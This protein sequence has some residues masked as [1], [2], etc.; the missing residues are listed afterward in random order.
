MKFLVALLVAFALYG[1]YAGAVDAEAQE[2]CKA[3][4]HTDVDLP[5][6]A[7]LNQKCLLNCNI[8][9]RIWTHFMN[10]DMPCPGTSSGVRQDFYLQ[11]TI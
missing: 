9:G 11:I 6:T 7:Y 2:K 5:D 8:H 1:S 10:E 3:I 4:H